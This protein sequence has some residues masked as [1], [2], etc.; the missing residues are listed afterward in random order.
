[1]A[2][3]TVAVTAPPVVQMPEL[4]AALEK[5]LKRSLRQPV[6]KNVSHAKG[7]KPKD[8]VA[9]VSGGKV[10]EGVQTVKQGKAPS[11]DALLLKELKTKR[12]REVCAYQLMKW[13]QE[14]RA[15]KIATVTPTR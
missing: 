14:Q 15:Q 10:P 4:P 5:C 3:E 1:V 7:G 6:P 11:A 12:D 13:F 2:V 9:G 8:D